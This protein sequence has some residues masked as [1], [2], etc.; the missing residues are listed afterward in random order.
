[1]AGVLLVKMNNT[2]SLIATAMPKPNNVSGNSKQLKYIS[3]S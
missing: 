2:Y 3:I 1:V